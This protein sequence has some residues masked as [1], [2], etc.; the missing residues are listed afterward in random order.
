VYGTNGSDMHARLCP[1]CQKGA[2]GIRY[3]RII[4]K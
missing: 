4:K 3:W 2:P 1:E